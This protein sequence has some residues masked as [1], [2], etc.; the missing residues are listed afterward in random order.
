M[1]KVAFLGL[2]AMGSRMAANLMKAGH[3]L[4]VWNR[5]ASAADALVARGAKLAGSP[6]EAAQAADVV[7]AMLRDDEVSRDVWLDGETGALAGMAPGSLAIESSTLTP[8]WVRTL[9]TSITARDVGFLEAPVSGSRPQAEAG[10]LIYLLGGD[11]ATAAKAEPLLKAMG[12]TIN[13]TGA[14][15]S[16]ALT[17]L[18]TNATLGIQ[19][20][21]YAE[22]I[23]MLRAA[24]ADPARILKAVATTPVWAPVAQ[25][26][27]GSMLSETF[28]PQFPVGLIDKDFRYA[29]EVSGSADKT[30]VIAT[31]HKVFQ[32][33][34]EKGLG[35]L[36]MT[37]VAKLYG[38]DASKS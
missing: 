29:L 20:A 2:G 27:T 10:Q 28:T 15:G 35:D 12:S 9:A 25:Y 19:V 11:E 34:I 21:A 26:L 3:D 22:I 37:S 5:T 14:V 18:A 8:G 33:G 32:T 1:T 36:N 23:G 7:I 13:L 16:G 38:Q 4:T 31:V 6:K 24:G 17:K 30:P